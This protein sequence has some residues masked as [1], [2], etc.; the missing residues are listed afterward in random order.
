[1]FTF[2]HGSVPAKRGQPISGKDDCFGS[3]SQTLRQRNGRELGTRAAT[4][5][6]LAGRGAATRSGRSA[7]PSAV[8]GEQNER[9]G[10]FK[11]PPSLGRAN[12]R[13]SS[14][15]SRWRRRPISGSLLFVVGGDMKILL[16]LCCRRKEGRLR[17]EERTPTRRDGRL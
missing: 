9:T 7:T 12:R 13:V 3:Q 2:V 6:D 4:Q 15:V 11:P 5:C 16:L 17:T 10:Q 1:M 8:P 14:L